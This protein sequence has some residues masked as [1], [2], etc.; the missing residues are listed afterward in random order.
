M[1]E[2]WITTTTLLSLPFERLLHIYPTMTSLI[3]A[4]GAFAG[5]GPRQ[6]PSATHRRFG[7]G[8]GSFLSTADL[9]L[10]G[11]LRNQSDRIFAAASAKGCLTFKEAL[12]PS[13]SCMAS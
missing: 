8:V 3:I 11:H 13:T 7:L 1:D 6:V 5:S 12:F 10:H 2:E 4:C 9:G